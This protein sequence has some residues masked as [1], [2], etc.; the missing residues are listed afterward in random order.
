MFEDEKIDGRPFKFE[1][2][3]RAVGIRDAAQQII[4]EVQDLSRT[5][6]IKCS[7]EELERVYLWCKEGRE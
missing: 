4:I 3:G 7:F 1:M 2:E 6:Y 5:V